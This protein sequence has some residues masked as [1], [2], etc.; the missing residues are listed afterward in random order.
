MPRIGKALYPGETMFD[1]FPESAVK[2]PNQEKLKEMLEEVG[3]SKVTFK[4]FHFGGVVLH[5]AIK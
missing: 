1:Y 2:Y 5:T 4:N 3:F